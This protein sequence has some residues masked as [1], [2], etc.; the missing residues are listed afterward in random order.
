MPQEG[1]DSN[2][3]GVGRGAS[4]MLSNCQAVLHKQ[5]S[6]LWY[7]KVTPFVGQHSSILANLLS[8]W[9]AITTAIGGE[10]RLLFATHL[11]NLVL[12]KLSYAGGILVCEKT[13]WHF[14]LFLLLLLRIHR[15]VFW[16]NYLVIG[17]PNNFGF[18]HLTWL[19]EWVGGCFPWMFLHLGFQVTTWT[20]SPQISVI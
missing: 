2:D 10:I 3:L 1:N 8:V 11:Q 7:R 15:K 5:G 13:C 16:P 9:G 6:L 18:R 20:F 4:G 19:C 14:F 12:I 17:S